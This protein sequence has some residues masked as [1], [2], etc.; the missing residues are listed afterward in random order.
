MTKTDK[1]TL[2]SLRREQEVLE[3]S[4][5][6]KQERVYEI[7]G[8]IRKINLKDYQQKLKKLGIKQGTILVGFA[9]TLGYHYDMIEVIQ[10]VSS[11]PSRRSIDYVLCKYRVDDGDYSFH[12][13]RKSMSVKQLTEWLNDHLVYT[14][15]ASDFMLLLEQMAALKINYENVGKLPAFVE[16][17]DDSRKITLD[18][19]FSEE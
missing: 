16:T 8:E 2:L 18:C 19:D 17:L 15:C 1:E 7:L 9:H 5:S 11:N 4:I 3:A 6:K 13:S 12:T 14:I 10:V